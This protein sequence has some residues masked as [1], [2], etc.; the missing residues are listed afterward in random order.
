VENSRGPEIHPIL[1]GSEKVTEAFIERKAWEK[2]VV[3]SLMELGLGDSRVERSKSLHQNSR[4]REVRSPE[5]AKEY[6][7]F[8][9]RRTCITRS[10]ISGTQTSEVRKG[11]HSTSQVVKL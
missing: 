3:G 11:V 8:A 1:Q 9:G 6:H 5:I 2:S 7:P 4:G 10:L